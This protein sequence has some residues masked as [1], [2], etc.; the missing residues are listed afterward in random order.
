MTRY[1]HLKEDPATQQSRLPEGLF[2]AAARLYQPA[3]SVVLP[4]KTM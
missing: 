4:Q 3:G 2:D 1:C